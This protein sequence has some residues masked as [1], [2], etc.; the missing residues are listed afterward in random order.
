MYPV[1][2]QWITLVFSV[3]L[4]TSGRSYCDP[5][6]ELEVLRDIY[7]SCCQTAQAC[8]DWQSLGNS[9]LGQ[10]GTCRIKGITCNNNLQITGIDASGFGLDCDSQIQ[11]LQLLEYLETLD[12]SNNQLSGIIP[13]YLSDSLVT[14]NLDNNELIGSIPISY[15]THPSLATLSA[16]NNK[17]I[18]LPIEWKSIVYQKGEAPFPL[19]VLRLAGNDL[20]GP[21]PQGLAYYPLLESLDVSNN[22]LSG[23]M[24]PATSEAFQSLKSLNVENNNLRGPI[25]DWTRYITNLETSGNDFGLPVQPSSPQVGAE[26]TGSSGSGLSGGAIAGIVIGTIIG[27]CLLVGLGIFGW[28]KHKSNRVPGQEQKFEKFVEN[29]MSHEKPTTAPPAV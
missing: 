12:L 26:E 23:E 9:T 25:P 14:L 3:V 10:D 29:I 5:V 24:G 27:V 16:G 1:F 8:A 20:E 4:A 21:F 19:K 2:S 6:V 11:E 13:H 18:G 28:K 7:R 15:A 22:Q 17:L